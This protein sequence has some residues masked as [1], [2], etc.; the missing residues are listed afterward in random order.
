MKAWRFLMPSAI[1]FTLKNVFHGVWDK[2]TGAPSR[3][4]QSMAYV[5]QHAKPGDPR[6]VLLT[7]DRFA[8]EVRWLMSVGPS[9]NRVFREVA[10][11][12]PDNPRVLELGAY[13]G[14]SSIVIATTLGNSANVT[15]VEISSDSV[16]AARANVAVA[17]LS[18][19]VKFIKGAS[20]DVIPTLSGA[21]DM[22]F[23]D[24]WKDLYLDD[25]KLI[26]QHGL[27]K[28]GS[29]VVADNV[30]E[31]FGA[32]RYLDYVRG[33]GAYRSENRADTIEYT[34]LPDAVEISTRL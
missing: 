27:L 34:E 14:Y 7:L 32:E 24:H 30:G 10:A 20:S 2:L 1:G 17:G 16:Q 4:L 33:C 29:V 22:V 11:Q 15:S 26:E 25:L 6:D 8:T 31:I 13:C 12:L 5:A 28:P 23:L 3:P 18:D 19:R 21:F 9:K